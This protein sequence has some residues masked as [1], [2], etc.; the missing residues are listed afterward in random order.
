[1][2]RGMIEAVG[3]VKLYSDGLDGS[4]DRLTIPWLHDH[5]TLDGNA[6]VKCHREGKDVE[7]KAANLSLRVI[8]SST[9]SAPRRTTLAPSTREDFV[10]PKNRETQVRPVSGTEQRKD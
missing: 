4:C 5:I 6:T 3:N 9:A 1:T 8:V 7:L 10:I 2:P